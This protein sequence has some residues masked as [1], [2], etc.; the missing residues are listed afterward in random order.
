MIPRAFF[1]FLFSLFLFS[2]FSFLFS[3]FLFSFF[4]FCFVGLFDHWDCRHPSNRFFTRHS[5]LLLLR[6][7]NKGKHIDMALPPHSRARDSRKRQDLTKFDRPGTDGRVA[8]HKLLASW[9]FRLALREK[10]FFNASG[11][12]FC[13]CL[14]TRTLFVSKCRFTQCWATKTNNHTDRRWPSVQMFRLALPLRRMPTAATG[15]SVRFKHSKRAAKR[16]SRPVFGQEVTLR[17]PQFP[18]EE[19]AAKRVCCFHVFLLVGRQRE[20]DQRLFVLCCDL[21]MWMIRMSSRLESSEQTFPSSSQFTWIIEITEQKWSHSCESTM[22]MRPFW[23]MNC[24]EFV[25][26]YV[27]SMLTWIGVVD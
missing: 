20:S 10:A 19:W 8:D 21:M 23:R 14:H 15:W 24:N 25:A 17:E 9:R 6:P 27:C 2:L 26:R 12:I 3:L 5:L 16:L 18:A 7:Q 4:S 13:F 1:A 11:E 22:A